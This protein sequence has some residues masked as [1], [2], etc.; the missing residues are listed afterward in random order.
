M[1]QIR[2]HTRT[3]P[4]DS[5]DINIVKNMKSKHMMLF[6]AGL[7]L[8]L[9]AHVSSLTYHQRFYDDEFPQEDINSEQS[10]SY[11]DQ[12]YYTEEDEEE[13]E[14]EYRQ[15]EEEEEE[16]YDVVE[17]AAD[18]HEP[19]GEFTHRVY[20]EVTSPTPP[21][22]D[23]LDDA[24]R[25]AVLNI[26]DRLLI[27][28]GPPFVEKL[29]KAPT[30][31][32]LATVPTPINIMAEP[33]PYKYKRCSSQTTFPSCDIPNNTDPEIWSQRF[34]LYFNLSSDLNKLDI[35][36][37]TL[38]LYKKKSIPL[39]TPKPLLIEAHAYTRSLTRRRSKIM[40]VA[41]K[42]VSSDYV[43]WV[44][45]S[46]EK[47]VK[48][49]RKARSNHGLQITVT[50]ADTIPWNA[51][52]IFVIMSC[53]SGLVPLPFEVQTDEVGQR[54]PALNIRQGSLD[55]EFSAGSVKRPTPSP[56][57]VDIPTEAVTG[58]IQSDDPDASHR[59]SLSRSHSAA[60]QN[61]YP[62]GVED[63]PASS[64]SNYPYVAGNYR[65]SISNNYPYGTGLV[66]EDVQGSGHTLHSGLEHLAKGISGHDRAYPPGSPRHEDPANYIITNQATN[67]H[68]S[69]NPHY[70]SSV[71][72]T[73]NQGHS[74]QG[75][76]D[77]QPDSRIHT[78]QSTMEDTILSQNSEEQ[79]FKSD[80][81]PQRE[82]IVST[83]PSRPHRQ[84]DSGNTKERRHRRKH[85]HQHS[86]RGEER[87][88]SATA[89][90]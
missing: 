79:I 7:V 39:R 81:I 66:H 28:L 45:L 84:R 71:H 30:N 41:E 48:R 22:Q 3:H 77:H 26:M 63:Y 62:H 43:G 89:A 32:T 10:S 85:H 75:P 58:Y 25:M 17:E 44:T 29:P 76:F 14:V 46:M 16:D 19:K 34:N 27:A 24:R 47:I 88:G 86:R 21:T 51:S 64:Y 57:P 1:W 49:W 50:D 36:N 23:P 42:S 87:H 72:H 2:A 69:N 31:D 55:D 40:L 5:R 78:T 80:W 18:P 82:P 90:L 61:T 9:S 65:P 15:E 60:T 68:H 13:E 67:N 8:T 20:D 6:V 4:K 11:N 37:A 56:R 73:R 83:E 59:Q 70:G 33:C 54:Y 12:D 74:V 38:R 53:S 35:I 52:R